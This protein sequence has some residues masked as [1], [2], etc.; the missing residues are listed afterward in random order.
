MWSLQ[1]AR[2]SLVSL[3][4]IRTP[5]YVIK[6]PPLRH[7]SFNLSHLL[8]AQP[9]NTVTLE[10]RASYEWGGVPFSL[11]LTYHRPLYTQCPLLKM[12]FIS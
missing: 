5:C 10:V 1:G 3:P 2:T 8:K 4:R 9:P 7:D 11:Q 12:L 6:T